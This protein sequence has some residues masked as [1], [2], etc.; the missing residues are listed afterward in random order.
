MSTPNHRIDHGVF[1][2]WQY[3][4]PGKKARGFWHGDDPVLV[5]LWAYAL[6]SPMPGAPSSSFW[7]TSRAKG[8]FVDEASAVNAARAVIEARERGAA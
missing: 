8:G 6:R 7:E 2:V 3:N 1:C 4:G 5:P